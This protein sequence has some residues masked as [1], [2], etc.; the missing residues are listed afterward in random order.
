MRGGN[1][2]HDAGGRLIPVISVLTFL[3]FQQPGGAVAQSV[4]DFDAADQSGKVTASVL[5]FDAVHNTDAQ[6]SS[7][8]I[9][10]VLIAS[11][12]PAQMI[13]GR[14]AVE[15]MVLDVASQYIGHPA[16]RQ[17]NLSGTDWIRLFRANIAIE[18]GF[19][20]TARSPVGAIGLGQL[21]PDT[22]AALGVD[23][24]DPAENLHGSA[25]YLLAQLQ[26]FGTPEFALAAYNAGPQAVASYDGIPPYRETINHV[27][28]VMAIYAV[29][30]GE[31]I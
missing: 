24:N 13:R 21:M 18:S 8:A 7:V 11:P 27:Q 22:A 25:R 5:D 17:A 20:P 14:A 2:Y 10:P 31:A 15:T 30:S 19:N 16:L 23:P 4:I 12:A 3:A 29:S 26:R 28:K 6:S 9:A 1:G